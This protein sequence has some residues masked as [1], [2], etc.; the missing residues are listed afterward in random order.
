MAKNTEEKDTKKN[1]VKKTVKH[2]EEK[3][4]KQV[5]TVE[6]KQ[7]KNEK[8]K[9]EEKN[10]KKTN[11]EEANKEVKVKEKV[12]VKQK[13]KAGKFI[14]ISL[15]FIIVLGCLGMLFM[16]LISPYYISLNGDKEI[17]VA[18]G[19][20][21]E[22]VGAVVKRFIFVANKDIE[23]EGSVDT[24]KYGDYKIV[25]K[26]DAMSVSRIIHVKDTEG[27]KFRVSEENATLILDVNGDKDIFKNIVVYDTN[28]VI[29]DEND[30]QVEENIDMST[31]GEYEVKYKVCDKSN[32]CNEYIRKVEV[33]D[34]TAPVITLNRT[35]LKIPVGNTYNEY[36]ASAYDNYDKN[37][38]EVNIESNVDTSKEGVYEVKYSICDSSNNCSEKIRKV[39]VFKQESTAKEE[40]KNIISIS[41]KY[42]NNPTIDGTIPSTITFNSNNKVVFVANCCSYMDTINGTYTIS[43][44]TITVT[45]DHAINTTKTKVYK[46]SILSS[47]KIKLISTVEA[48][49]PYTGDVFTK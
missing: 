14:V 42:T 23:V 1:D 25:Y 32:N 10:T 2:K 19:D 22:E 4:L 16:Y 34:V 47:S 11:F 41:G 46:F 27:P 9:E 48:C 37:L 13:N 7:K 39:T 38:D 28:G 44:T 49:A 24:S 35:D 12:E 15:I 33:K 5:E 3:L 30:V 21:Y 8:P 31:P 17:T 18:L 6:D 29:I 40:T 36:G 43:G 26:C 20:S 45:L